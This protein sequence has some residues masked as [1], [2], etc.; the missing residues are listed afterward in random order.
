MSSCMLKSLKG[1]KQQQHQRINNSSHPVLTAP[2]DQRIV[3]VLATFLGSFFVCVC[4][5]GKRQKY[6]SAATN[7]ISSHRNMYLLLHGVK[8]PERRGGEGSVRACTSIDGDGGVARIHRDLMGNPISMEYIK[9]G[10]V[11]Y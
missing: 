3:V 8:V 1:Q 5:C 2:R 4:G 10:S 6:T 11:A 7:L 9:I